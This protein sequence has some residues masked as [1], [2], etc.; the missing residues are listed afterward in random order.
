[1]AILMAVS[2]VEGN[3]LDRVKQTGMQLRHLQLLYIIYSFWSMTAASPHG[4]NEVGVKVW[5]A[6]ADM[7]KAS[8]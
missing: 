2:V 1:M 5:G 7:I 8:R 4:P 6:S 3:E